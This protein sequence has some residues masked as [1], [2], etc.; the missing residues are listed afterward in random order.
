MG[1]IVSSLHIL[2]ERIFVF[3]CNLNFFL[4]WFVS[5][6]FPHLLNFPQN[7]FSQ[8]MFCFSYFYRAINLFL[9][10]VLH[11]GSC[12]RSM[13]TFF[14]QSGLEVNHSYEKTLTENA[15]GN[16]HSKAMYASSK[17]NVNHSQAQMCL[18]SE[19]NRNRARNS[20][21]RGGGGRFI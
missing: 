18:N 12:L 19:G 13:L 3:T 4:V 21:N 1:H 6:Y 17:Q 14:L 16:L 7:Y 11:R 5:L 8:N 9:T 20:H 15:K 2:K 10:F